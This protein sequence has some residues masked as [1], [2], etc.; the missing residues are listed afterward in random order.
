MSFDRNKF[1]KNIFQTLVKDCMS[2]CIENAGLKDEHN[3]LKHD[4]WQYG[5]IK[6]IISIKNKSKKKQII[7]CLE[8]RNADLRQISENL[9]KINNIIC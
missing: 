7:F 9:K 1:L 3:A 8:S 2:P 5:A 6:E 4:S